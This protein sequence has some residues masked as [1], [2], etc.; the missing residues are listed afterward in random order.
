MT[1]I[2]DDAEQRLGAAL[3]GAKQTEQDSIEAM[4]DEIG[5]QHFAHAKEG[6]VKLERM[7]AEEIHP[8]LARITALCAKAPTPL[9]QYIVNQL[10]AMHTSCDKVPPFIRE[11]IAGWGELRVPLM[12]D[13]R[14]VDVNSRSTLIYQTR[15]R[16]M[17]WNGQESFLQNMKAQVENYLKESGWPSRQPTTGA[18]G[19]G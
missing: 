1:T 9:P 3:A 6:L 12:A 17:N 14:S 13:G 16:L 11:G 7:I 10:Q 8:F 4:R 2:L 5:R 19:K 18:G 15:R